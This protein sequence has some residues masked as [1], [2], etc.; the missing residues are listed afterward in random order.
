LL[1][2]FR[3]APF[4]GRNIRPTL[5][6]LWRQP[7]RDRWRLT[8]ER[9]FRYSEFSGRLADEDGD[10]VFELGSLDGDIRILDARGV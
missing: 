3:H 8:V 2:G 9:Q 1:I 4:R 6:K 7:R 10:R 5:Q